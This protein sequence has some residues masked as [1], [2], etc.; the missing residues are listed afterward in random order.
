MG[1][2]AK[3]SHNNRMVRKQKHIDPVQFKSLINQWERGL[4]D[5]KEIYETLQISRATLA[6]R[7]SEYNNVYREPENEKRKRLFRYDNSHYKMNAVN[8]ADGLQLMN[9]INDDVISAA[10]FDP[11]YEGILKYLQYGNQDRQRARLSLPQMSDRQIHAFIIELYRIIKPSGY[12]FLWMDVFSM[13]ESLS[14][15]IGNIPF[16]KTSLITW[17]K[18]ISGTGWRARHRSEYLLLLITAVFRT[19]IDGFGW[20]RIGG[21][22]VPIRRLNCTC[23]WCGEKI[24][25]F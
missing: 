14:D 24:W 2:L 19:H 3:M 11:E 15:W 12:L 17:D 6:R 20:Y 9:S 10:F 18:G 5:Q 21:P 8:I 1:F 25:S 4:I 16:A 13:L 22:L 23:P 7:L